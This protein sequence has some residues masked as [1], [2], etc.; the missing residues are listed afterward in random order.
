MKATGSPSKFTPTLT[1]VTGPVIT[2]TR[3]CHAGRRQ[4]L[5]GPGNEIVAEQEDMPAAHRD[6]GRGGTVTAPPPREKANWS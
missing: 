6:G 5:I 2:G 1:P 4:L 3:S